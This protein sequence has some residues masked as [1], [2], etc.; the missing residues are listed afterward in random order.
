MQEAAE[1]M[2]YKN[3]Y[4]DDKQRYAQIRASIKRIQKDLAHKNKGKL[5]L[6]VIDYLQLIHGDKRL[7]RNYQLEEISRGIK[8]LAKDHELCVLALS[9]LSREVDNRKDNKPLPSDLRD[10]GS[11]E[12]DCDG[13][14]LM[15]LMPTIKGRQG[16]THKNI[17]SGKK[18][19]LQI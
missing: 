16:I 13:L 14:M 19:C 4:I 9:Q 18:K 1:T 12:Q 2:K 15:Y 11:F 5:G 3:L 17:L 8:E 10:S 6:I 7:S